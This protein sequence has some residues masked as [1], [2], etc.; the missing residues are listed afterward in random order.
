[1]V[2]FHH[3][4]GCWAACAQAEVFCVLGY[5]CQRTFVPSSEVR[6]IWILTLVVSLSRMGS[7]TGY[8]FLT[9]E[10]KIMKQITYLISNS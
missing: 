7:W 2:V 4:G 5:I 8:L 6:Q 10:S 9:C 1:M 3:E